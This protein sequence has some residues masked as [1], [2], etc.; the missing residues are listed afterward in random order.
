MTER[1]RY[2]IR[3]L[4]YLQTANWEKCVEEYSELVKQ[5]P[6][7]NIGY[8]NLSVCYRSLHNT[9]KAIEE[10]QHTLEVLPHNQFARV[11]LALYLSYTGDFQ[12][13]EREAKTVL[14]GNPSYEVGYVALASAQTGQG[15]LEDAVKTYE[16]LE[17]VS[18]LGKTFAEPGLA[19]IAIYEGR[20]ADASRLLQQG[21][22]EARK[23]DRTDS[24]AANL[25]LLGYVELL[26][27]HKPAAMAALDKATADSKSDSTRFLAA[28]AY[29]LAG[30]TDKARS[31]ATQLAA[32]ATP[33]PQ[34]NAKLIEGEI[35]L[36]EKDPRKAIEL[37]SA[38]DKLV[39]SWIADF[40]LG[41]AYLDAGQYVEADSEFDRC[42]KNRG[43]TFDLFDYVSTYGYVPEVYYYQGRVREQLKSPGAADSYRTYMNIRGKAGEDPLLPEVRHRLGQ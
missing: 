18:S 26:R 33:E 31:L 21:A 9:P 28:R 37:F 3:G 16:Q 35:A 42:L 22:D 23:A 24:A 34:A 8:N 29:V 7:D 15:R 27:K 1:E 2:R 25:A 6:A 43:A 32:G 11:N 30:E 10:L 17:K 20:L 14:E 40:D 41:R 36:Q 5:Y 19:D 39:K 13:G 4:Y 12:G 38:S